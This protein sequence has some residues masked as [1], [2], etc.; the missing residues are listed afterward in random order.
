MPP[1][2]TAPACSP[3]PPRRRLRPLPRRAG[4]ARPR[5]PEPAAQGTSVRP[6]NCPDRYWHISDGYVR[7]DPVASPADRRAAAFTVVKGLAESRCY[8]FDGAAMPESVGLSRR[9]RRHP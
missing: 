8:S 3:S 2:T 9:K 1:W 5:S 4:A 7:L 6:L